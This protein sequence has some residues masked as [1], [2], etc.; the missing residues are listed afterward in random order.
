MIGDDQEIGRGAEGGL[1]ISEKARIDVPVGTD[2]GELLNAGVEFSR[3]APLDGI[4]VEVTV[5]V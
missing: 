5:G 4:R 2:N 1:G 3:Y